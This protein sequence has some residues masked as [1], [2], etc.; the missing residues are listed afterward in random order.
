VGLA[1]TKKTTHPEIQSETPTQ[2]NDEATLQ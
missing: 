2:R 1:P